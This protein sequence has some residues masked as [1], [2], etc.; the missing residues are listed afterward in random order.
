MRRRMVNAYLSSVISI[1]MV[2][3]LVGIASMILVNTDSI[4]NY[5]KENMKISVIMLPEVSE[6]Q[7]LDYKT[8]VDSRPFIHTAEFVS[9]R[10]G[11]EE[12]KQMLGEDFLSVFETS[13][14]PVSID[15][16]LVADYVVEDSLEVVKNILSESSLVDEVVYQKSLVDDLNANLG[17]ISAILGVFIILLL[18]IS[19]VLIS[20]T[21]R[22]NVYARRFTIHTMKLVGATRSF[23]RGPFLARAAI[24]GVFSALIAIMIL[25]GL[26]FVIRAELSSM[27]EL[28]DLRLL[29]LAMGIVL[30]S[31]VVICVVSSYFVVNK[32]L[33]LDKSE[34]YY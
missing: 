4:S 3:L 18:F 12:M 19:F 26:L 5:F 8:T 24:L 23:I 33:S 34:L 11:E 20:N 2:L 9:R 16:T 15:I 31:G 10:Q 30:A 27:F 21:V 1:S 22:L 6:E 29:L 13:P 17:K 7:A 32:L 25:V 14:I 28:F